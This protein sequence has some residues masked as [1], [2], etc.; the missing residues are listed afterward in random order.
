MDVWACDVQNAY[1]QDPV[2]KKCCI[3]YGREFV[4]KNM[5]KVAIIRRVVH[6]RKAPSRDFRNRIRHCIE[7]LGFAA[8]LVHPNV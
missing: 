1:L 3:V 2:T 7:H 8:F 5:D 4:L 6:D